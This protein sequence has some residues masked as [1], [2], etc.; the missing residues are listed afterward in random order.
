MVT[1][2]VFKSRL[3]LPHCAIPSLL[4]GLPSSMAY[5]KL[6]TSWLEKTH[7]EVKRKKGDQWFSWMGEVGPGG[8]GRRNGK[9]NTGN[10]T[11]KFFS[12]LSSP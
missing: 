1:S 5:F 6:R 10:V 7:A 2:L 8:S 12:G 11:F 9:M 4:K 3:N